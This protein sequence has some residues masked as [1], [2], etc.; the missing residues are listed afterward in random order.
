M[1]GLQAC[2]S[3]RQAWRRIPSPLLSEPIEQLHE[4]DGGQSHKAYEQQEVMGVIGRECHMS[5]GCHAGS[6]NTGNN[7]GNNNNNGDDNLGA[8]NVGNSNSGELLSHSSCKA[9][10][11]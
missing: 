3:Q 5:L 11:S 2:N 4:T 10:L 1:S 6:G 8:S 7:N 9:L